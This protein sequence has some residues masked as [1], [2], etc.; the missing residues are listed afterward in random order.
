MEESTPI[1][2]KLYV[3]MLLELSEPTI[4]LVDP[5]SKEYIHVIIDI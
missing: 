4:V 2:A 5:C 1:K 3:H